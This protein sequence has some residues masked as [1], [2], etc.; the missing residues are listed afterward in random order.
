DGNVEW[1]GRKDRRVSIRGFRVELAEVESALRQCA[2]VKRSAVVVKDFGMGTSNDLR[3]IAYV[4]TEQEQSRTADELRC[5]LSATLPRYMMPSYFL[6]MDHLPLNPNGKVD[7]F[8]LP[9]VAQF[10]DRAEDQCE[11]PRTEV[12][13]TLSKIISEVLSLQQIG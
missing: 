10:R 4:E 5:S 3:L 2:G 12:E 8:G 9:P 13:Q 1:V 11:A 7:Y 6:L